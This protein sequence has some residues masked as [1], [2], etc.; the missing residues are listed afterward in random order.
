MSVLQNLSIFDVHQGNIPFGE[1]SPQEIKEEI[2]HRLPEVYNRLAEIRKVS[3][4]TFD[5]VILP[6]ERST[7]DVDQ[8]YMLFSHERVACDTSEHQEVA[9]EITRIMTELGHQILLDEKIFNQVAEVYGTEKGS[10]DLTQEQSML[11]QILYD[12]FCDN[13]CALD[14]AN[15][16]RLKDI[17]FRLGQLRLDFGNKVLADRQQFIKCITEDEARG[18][19]DSWKKQAKSDA[20]DRGYDEGY[21]V[22]LDYSRLLPV[23]TYSQDRNL[24]EELYR[25]MMSLGCQNNDHNTQDIIEEIAQLRK[26]KAQLLGYDT[27]ADYVLR[28]RMAQSREQVEEL[29][30]TLTQTARPYAHKDIACLQEYA[31]QDGVTTLQPWDYAFYRE[32]ASQD[33]FSIEEEVLRQY[34]PLN[35]VMTGLFEV[36]HRLYGLSF[37]IVDVPVYHEDVT[38]YD[39]YQADV[40]IGRLYLDVYVREGK[41]SGAWM[42]P[43]VKKHRDDSTEYAPQVSV[44]TNF[45]RI[46]NPLLTFQDVR[47]LFHECGH[48]LHELLAQGEYQSLTGTSVYWDVVEVPSQLLENWLYQPQVMEMISSHVET[49]EPL[50]EEMQHILQGLRTFQEGY[51]TMRQVL[52]AQL[53]LAWHTDTRYS[54]GEELE[55]DVW[56]TYSLFSHIEGCFM[57]PSFSHIFQGGYAAGYYSYKWAEY[58]EADVFAVFQDQGIFN[59]NTAKRFRE[60][61]LETGGHYRPDYL[62]TEFLGRPP[63]VKALLDRA[64]FV[65]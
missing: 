11:L 8:L 29:L 43:F 55:K 6:L 57:S 24:R 23:F 9:P 36:I 38:V 52:F 48:A 14:T 12:S 62:Y 26:Q 51:A 22:T 18:L 37:Q 3:Q 15:Q 54:S 20:Y 28:R 35:K 31:S 60:L 59:H 7:Y 13:G 27:Y 41:K 25:A 17:S 39:V 42:A 2:E 40:Q 1:F 5:S 45:D 46:E 16:D 21:L 49:G 50:P 47:T 58:I 53:D 63:Q 56:Q 64:G 19:P 44:N 61:I 10:K 32:K 34:F 33:L 65:S 30:D 4:P